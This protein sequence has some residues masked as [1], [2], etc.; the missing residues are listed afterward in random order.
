ML[1]LLL[2][3]SLVEEVWVVKA[4]HVDADV[5][6]TALNQLSIEPKT[7]ISYSLPYI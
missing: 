4:M 7:I 1:E 5:S 3:L 2:R 6:L